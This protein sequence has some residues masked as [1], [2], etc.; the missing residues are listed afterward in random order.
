MTANHDRQIPAST[1]HLLAPASPHQLSSQV[2][3]DNDDDDDDDKATAGT[4]I[5]ELHSSFRLAVAF[6]NLEGKARKV[7]EQ[8]VL[9]RY[10]EME[11]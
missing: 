1:K 9:G 6:V 2:Q 5:N 11:A 7:W 3:S 4:P 10:L 8:Q